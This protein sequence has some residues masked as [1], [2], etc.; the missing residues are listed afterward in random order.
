MSEGSF[1]MLIYQ[2]IFLGFGQVDP[3]PAKLFY[4]SSVT[5]GRLMF[6]GFE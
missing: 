4:L 3:K 2:M 5:D 1:P 6:V